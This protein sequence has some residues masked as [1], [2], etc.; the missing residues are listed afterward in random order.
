V[1]AKKALLRKESDARR[2]VKLQRVGEAVFEQGQWS[3]NDETVCVFF[4]Y[5]YILYFVFVFA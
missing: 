5:V 2:K 1:Y 4:T 3:I